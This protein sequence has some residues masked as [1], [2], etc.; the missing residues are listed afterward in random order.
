VRAHT[1]APDITPA[2]H[3]NRQLLLDAMKQGGFTNYAMEWWHYTLSPEPS[4][5]TIY[6]VP[7]Q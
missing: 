4:P 1:D 3:A 7:V 2:Q 5:H 6:D